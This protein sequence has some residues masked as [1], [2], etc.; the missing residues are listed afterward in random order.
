MKLSQMKTSSILNKFLIPALLATAVQS[1][2]FA[3]APE[4]EQ[5][6]EKML[7]RLGGRSV[8]S[9]LKNTINGSTQNRKQEPTVVY[10]I[11][12][13]DFE[14]ARFRIDTT[15]EDVNLVRVVNGESS[16][17]IGW[18]GE[19]EDLPADRFQEEMRW[20]EAHVYRTIHRIAARDPLI[21]LALADENRLEVYNGKT[22]LLWL[23]LDDK[24]EPY[25]F[26]FWN[27]DTGSLSGPWDVVKNGIH[28]PSWVSSADGTWRAAVKALEVNVPLHPSTFAR[29]LDGESR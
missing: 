4:A 29:P 14:S 22:R 9:N 23:K 6:A 2:A 27:D 11:I 28:H 18:G 10:S 24:A 8:W 1:T 12:T 16:W 26:G 7:D 5:L 17:K 25:A 20:Y 13:M 15:A 19:V 21:S 3:D